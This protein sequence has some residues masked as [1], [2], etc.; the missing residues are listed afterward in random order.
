[1]R[2]D[3]LHRRSEARPAPD[4]AP[5]LAERR[6]RTLTKAIVRVAGQLGLAQAE[7]GKV[8]GVSASTVSRMFK[9][10]WLIPENDKTWELAAMLL[11][12]FR[13]LDALVGGNEHHVREWFHAENTHL[14]GAPAELIFKIEG[15]TR[16]AGYLDAMRGAA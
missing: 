13:S 8:L 5:L 11:R 15:L 14:G 4:A 1:M 7:L 2:R 12:I 6:S 16:V 3:R 10:E 9:H